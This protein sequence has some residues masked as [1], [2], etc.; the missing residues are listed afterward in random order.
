MVFLVS[1]M[2]YL[3]SIAQGIQLNKS[4]VLGLANK[5]AINFLESFTSTQR[6]VHFSVNIKVLLHFKSICLIYHM[7]CNPIARRAFYSNQFLSG[8]IHHHSAA[9]YHFICSN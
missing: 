9:L 2:H 1:S 7:K 3:V 8:E 6:A 5:R 4:T